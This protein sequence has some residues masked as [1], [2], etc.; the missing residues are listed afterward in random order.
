[1]RLPE[2]LSV[3]TTLSKSEIEKICKDVEDEI[4][5]LEEDIDTDD[6][7]R[8][9]LIKITLAVVIFIIAFILSRV[10]SKSLL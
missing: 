5:L 2:C 9:D 10:L 3:K 8:N 6:S 1:M 7:Q 4:V